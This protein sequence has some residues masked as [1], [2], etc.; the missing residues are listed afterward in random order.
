[1]SDWQFCT[2]Q[3]SSFKGMTCKPHAEQKIAENQF[4][5]ELEVRRCQQQTAFPTVYIGVEGLVQL[6][7]AKSLLEAS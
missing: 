5:A 4:R 2:Q 6:V 7:N 3:F 1:M